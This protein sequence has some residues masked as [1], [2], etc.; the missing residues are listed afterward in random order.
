[1]ALLKYQRIASTWVVD[2]FCISGTPKWQTPA[3]SIH[4]VGL[5][6]LNAKLNLDGVVEPIFVAGY[7]WLDK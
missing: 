4:L 5:H 3:K 7:I 6:W 2:I 1:M